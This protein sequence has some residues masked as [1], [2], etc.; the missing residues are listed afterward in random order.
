MLQPSGNNCY[1]ISVRKIQKVDNLEI[2]NRN[3]P[4]YEY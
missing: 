4:E 2:K 3:Y 1:F